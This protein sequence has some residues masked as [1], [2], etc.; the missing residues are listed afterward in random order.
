[1]GK[2]FHSW[3]SW[4]SSNLD[5]DL[6]NTCSDIPWMEQ[7][8]SDNH[9][10]PP[11]CKLS[12]FPQE[13]LYFNIYWLQFYQNS[14][15]LHLIK[16][17]LDLEGSRNHLEDR[18]SWIIPSGYLKQVVGEKVPLDSPVNNCFHPFVWQQIYLVVICR[19]WCFLFLCTGYIWTIIDIIMLMLEI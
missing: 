8:A 10:H 18:S 5:I 11:L 19:I 3:N 16:C 12:F 2:E 4:T 7:L 14:R 17:C 6:R 15:T 9:N 13:F 1:M